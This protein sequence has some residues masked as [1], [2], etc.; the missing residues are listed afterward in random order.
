MAILDISEGAECKAI[1]GGQTLLDTVYVPFIFMEFSMIKL[2][3]NP[4]PI[5]KEAEVQFVI[6]DLTRRGYTAR[7]LRTKPQG[8]KLNSLQ[9]KSW[10]QSTF[11]LIWTHKDAMEL[12]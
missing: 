6:D 5:C 2:M 9:W 7:D 10:S 4:S 12:F 8:K 1:S 11:D 3:K